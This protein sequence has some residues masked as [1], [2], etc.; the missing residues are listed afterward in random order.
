MT[1]K[2]EDRP[3]RALALGGAALT[4][5]RTFNSGTA[6]NDGPTVRPQGSDRPYRR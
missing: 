6:S 3:S 4:A 5:L 1:S 2:D